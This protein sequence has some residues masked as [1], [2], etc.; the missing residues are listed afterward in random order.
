MS[1]TRLRLSK[2][3]AQVTETDRRTPTNHDK[4]VQKTTGSFKQEKKVANDVFW[5]KLTMNN[6]NGNTST[7]SSFRISE[8]WDAVP[9]AQ[10][11]DVNYPDRRLCAVQGRSTPYL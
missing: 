7:Y 3:T 10:I 11:N 9:G 2:V 4:C 6:D 5:E 8:R 1:E